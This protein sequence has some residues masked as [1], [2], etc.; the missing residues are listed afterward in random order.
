MYSEQFD[1]DIRELFDSLSLDE[2][3][4]DVANTLIQYAPKFGLSVAW[5]DVQGRIV[6]KDEVYCSGCGLSKAE[7]DKYYDGGCECDDEIFK[8]ITV[9]DE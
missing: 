2:H 1:K 6:L 5:S 3:S 4:G 9:D 7:S 8:P